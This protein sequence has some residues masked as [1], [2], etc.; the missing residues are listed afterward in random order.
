MRAHKVKAALLVCAGAAVAATAAASPA[1]PPPARS[2][3]LVDCAHHPQTRPS[4]FLLACGDGNYALTSLRWSQWQPGSAH[5]TGSAVVNNCVPYC[6]AGRFHTYQ[7]TVRLDNP[8]PWP[9]HSGQWHYTRLS[10]SPA[11]QTPPLTPAVV[12]IQLWN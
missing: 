5:G 11:G 9:G 1:P 7:V 3:I 2:A 12:S 4:S 10:V 8:Q 6:A